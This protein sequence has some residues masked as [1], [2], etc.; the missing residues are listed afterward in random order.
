MYCSFSNFFGPNKFGYHVVLDFVLGT[1]EIHWKLVSVKEGVLHFA[2][3]SQA[4]M[5]V[6]SYLLHQPMPSR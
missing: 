3:W 1:L 4:W 2:F 5:I 6:K